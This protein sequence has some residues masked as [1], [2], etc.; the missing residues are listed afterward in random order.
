[1][2]TRRRLARRTD[3]RPAA[4]AD[5][6]RG[7]A[8]TPRHRRAASAA[9]VRRPRLHARSPARRSRASRTSRRCRSCRRQNSPFDNDPF[10]QYFFGD[11]TTVRLARSPL[12]EP[13][14]RRHRLGRRLRRHQQP[15]RRRER[16]ARSPSRCRT[17]ARCK[18][19]SIG[20]DPATDIALLKID[21][22]R[23]AGRCRGATRAS[24]R[25]AN[26]CW[27]SAARFSSARP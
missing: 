26:G 23:P 10:F 6:S 14:L 24:C 9:A 27:R 2:R 15:R 3:P 11:R 21:V 22:E 4:A 12:A 18:G 17:S 7:A 5:T 16:R 25:S 20:T 13:R 8:R 19:A 1:M